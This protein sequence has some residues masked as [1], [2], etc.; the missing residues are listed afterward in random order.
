MNIETQSPC[1]L[2]RGFR[3]LL[4]PGPVSQHIQS[5]LSHVR[6]QLGRHRRCC[7]GK[8]AEVVASGLRTDPCVVTKGQNGDRSFSP[9][10]LV[11]PEITEPGQP[12]FLFA[13]RPWNTLLFTTVLN[14]HEI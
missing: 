8:S 5:H 14:S 2:G 10:D 7:Q 9:C 1:E 13:F 3:K 11:I 6:H 12:C 4:L